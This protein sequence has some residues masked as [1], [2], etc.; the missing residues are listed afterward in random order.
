MA[1]TLALRTQDKGGACSLEY[2]QFFNQIPCIMSGLIYHVP[3]RPGCDPHD[4]EPDDINGRVLQ[5]VS[6]E[7]F[8]RKLSFQSYRCVF[9]SLCI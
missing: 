1:D 9:R 6:N 2:E 8:R 4:V 7:D 3:C 5:T